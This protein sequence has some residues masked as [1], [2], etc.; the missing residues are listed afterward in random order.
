[1]STPTNGTLVSVIVP[2][3]GTRGVVGGQQRIFVVDAVR[4][5]LATAT[6]ALEVIVVAG[7]EMPADVSAT[8]VGIGAEVRIVEYDAPF[9]FSAT[10]DLGAAHARG[11]QLLL[12]NDDT[13]VVTPTWLGAML[14]AAAEPVGGKPVGAVGA[15]CCSRTVPSSTQGTRTARRSTTSA[16]ACRAT[17][18]DVAGSS[19]G[20]ARSPASPQRAC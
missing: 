8:L 11:D 14:A 2:S 9:N 10:I 17:V 1:M 12:L 18:A 6:V 5:V 7:R 13:E 19:L 3:I 16:S 15:A 20:D 4:S